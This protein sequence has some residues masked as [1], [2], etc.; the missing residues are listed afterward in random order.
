MSQ[1]L[2]VMQLLGGRRGETGKVD[3]GKSLKLQVPCEEIDFY[4]T[5]ELDLIPSLTAG[6][7]DPASANT[8]VELYLGAIIPGETFGRHSQCMQQE[9]PQL[10]QCLSSQ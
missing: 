9:S 10:V 4:P 7:A 3:K 5:T 8:A 6:G 1:G 2:E